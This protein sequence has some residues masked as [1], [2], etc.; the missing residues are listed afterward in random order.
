MTPQGR[1]GYGGGGYYTHRDFSRLL[2]HPY[3]QIFVELDVHGTF[4]HDREVCYN[5]WRVTAFGRREERSI[6]VV[7]PDGS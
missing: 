3:A 7:A 4:I 2:A 1:S 5:P 6:G